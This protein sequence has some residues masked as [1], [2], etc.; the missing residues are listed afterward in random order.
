[1]VCFA[2]IFVLCGPSSNRQNGV[3][4]NNKCHQSADYGETISNDHDLKAIFETIQK[5]A[6]SSSDDENDDKV[7]DIRTKRGSRFFESMYENPSSSGDAARG[8][9]YDIP[10]Y[11]SLEE[12]SLSE[13]DLKVIP[14]SVAKVLGDDYVEKETRSLQDLL[15]AMS[16]ILDARPWDPANI[17]EETVQMLLHLLLCALD[18]QNKKFEQDFFNSI[19][20]RIS[21]DDWILNEKA[22]YGKAYVYHDEKIKA[23]I[24]RWEKGC[25][26]GIHDHGTETVALY[27]AVGSDSRL[28][29]KVYDKLPPPSSSPN[30]DS[31]SRISKEYD[32]ILE[33]G[34]VSGLGGGPVA[35]LR[36]HHAHAIHNL[37][38]GY[39]YTIHI[40]VPSYEFGLAWDYGMRASVELIRESLLVSRRS[41]TYE[42]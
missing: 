20:D 3:I 24:Y 9:A 18:G 41:I 17:D 37:S 29:N 25:I 36:P 15:A 14:N 5:D 1:M 19:A 35:I 34:A 33:G 12:T 21:G 13:E 39:S 32:E 26:A 10:S 40:Y 30:N 4:S 42:G 16:K 11:S 23:G 2:R 22:G 7:P 8:I 27:G 31:S 6:S 28:L 38:D